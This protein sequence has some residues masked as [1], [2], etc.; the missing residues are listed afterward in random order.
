MQNC[1][2]GRFLVNTEN[3]EARP[4]LGYLK[5]LNTELHTGMPLLNSQA[6]D[7]DSKIQNALPQERGAIMAAL[8]VFSGKPLLVWIKR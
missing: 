1:S 6:E 7:F 4:M 2:D 3:Y 8:D 5:F